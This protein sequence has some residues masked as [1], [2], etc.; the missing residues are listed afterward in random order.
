M[1][2][3][4]FIIICFVNIMCKYTILNFLTELF[5]STESHK[6]CEAPEIVLTLGGSFEVEHR[7]DSATAQRRRR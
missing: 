7:D 5:T 2:Y 4:L 6:R 1:L 3:Y